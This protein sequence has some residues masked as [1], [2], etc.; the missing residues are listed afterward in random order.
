MIDVQRHA[1]RLAQFFADVERLI[2]R[3]HAG[4]VGRI[5]GMQRLD[6]NLDARGLGMGQHGG[7]TVGHLLAGAGQ[8]LG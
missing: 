3:V 8:V 7:N 6:G 4:P 2:D 1:D 5:H